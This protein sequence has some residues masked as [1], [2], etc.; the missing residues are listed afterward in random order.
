MAL[1]CGARSTSVSGPSVTL[2]LPLGS[3]AVVPTASS[4][5]STWRHSILPLDEWLKIFSIVSR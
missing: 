3:W 4:S 2:T 5:D 1:P